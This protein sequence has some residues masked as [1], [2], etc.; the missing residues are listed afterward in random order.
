MTVDQYPY[1]ASSTNLNAMMPPWAGVLQSVPTSDAAT[2]R[3]T[4]DARPGLLPKPFLQPAYS[5]TRRPAER[6]PAAANPEG[7]LGLRQPS[8]RLR[9]YAQ[10]LRRAGPRPS[11]AAG[12][13]ILT[14]T[15]AS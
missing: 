4:L 9:R 12:A 14:L 1:R 8:W 15:S 3:A 13:S 11:S 2:L 10:T 5:G 7:R 6:R